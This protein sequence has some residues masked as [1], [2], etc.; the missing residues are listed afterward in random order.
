MQRGH[1]YKYSRCAALAGARV[2]WVD[3]IVAALATARRR[4]RSCTRRIS[5][6]TALRLD[7]L[8]P[9]A[10]AAGVPVVVDAAF[11]SFPMSE[12]ERWANA[13]DLAC[14]SAK[15][16]WGPNAGGF[17]AGR[18]VRSRTSPRSTSPAMRPGRGGRSVARSSSIARPWS[19][20]L[21]PWRSG[22]RS[23]TMPASPA[24][25]R[26]PRPRGALR[27]LPGARVS[28]DSSHLTNGWWTVRSMRC[29][30]EAQI[31]CASR[32]GSPR[33]NPSI[34]AMAEGDALVF[35]T[36][37]LRAGEVDEIA[38]ALSASGKAWTMVERLTAMPR[39]DTSPLTLCYLTVPRDPQ[40]IVVVSFAVAPRAHRLA[41]RLT[42]WASR[43]RS[44]RD[45][46]QVRA[47]TWCVGRMSALR[48]TASRSGS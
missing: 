37:A 33:G 45:P 17:V 46:S 31:R 4:R 38:A 48:L 18:P 20:R 16:F 1:E 36:E 42:G 35:C 47:R 5:T 22:W 43:R 19:R 30:C 32:P 40:S 13:G 39:S 25:R 6:T 26:S 2:E 28:S 8:A 24:T 27:R 3:D 29:W 41:V 14:F 34:R 12:L 21:R 7:E 15:Y 10:R 23:I 9:L 11:L 44:A